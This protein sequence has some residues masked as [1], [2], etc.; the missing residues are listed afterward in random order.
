ME[1]IYS[2]YTDNGT[3]KT[4]NQDALLVEKG[5]IE[6]DLFHL[7]LVCDG[8]GGLEKGEVASGEL[9]N[10]FAEWFRRE[11]PAIWKEQ[12]GGQAAGRIERSLK[13]LLDRENRKIAAYGKGRRISLGSTVS[14]ML[15]VNDT[16]YIIHVGD[17]RIY[18]VSGQLVQLTKDHTLVAR[19]IEQ[20]RIR[21]E[22]AE[23]DSRRNV[24]L[25]CIGASEEIEPQFL[26]GLIRKDAVYFLCSDGFRH[27]LAA[28][29]ML[30]GFAPEQLTSSQKIG[31]ICERLSRLAM[32]RG[33]QDNIT[34]LAA[35]SY[36]E[37]N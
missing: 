8:M 2:Y 4:T 31:E 13:E 37:D 14:A 36:K 17:C 35:R 34:V 3:E 10:S 23:S 5:R 28:G 19:D 32:N 1:F 25:Q 20:G 18:E 6:N 33:E 27:E 7:F 26:T 29:E 30:Q 16:Y 12:S 11:L 24:L 9:V 15:T 22:D 21:P